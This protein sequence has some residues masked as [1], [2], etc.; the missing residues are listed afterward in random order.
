MR[1]DP[2]IQACADLVARGDPDR[3][4]ATLAAAVPARASLL[5]LYAFNLE[6]ARAPWVT[7]EPMIAEMR[8]QFWHDVIAEAA[9]GG[10]AK[11]HEVAGPFS[12]L[13]RHKNLKTDPL[14]A[15]VEARRWDIYCDPFDDSDAFERYLDATG[16]GLMWLAAQLLGAPEAFQIVIRGFG[17]AAAI[18]RLFLA[19][20]ELTRRRRRPLLDDRPGAIRDLAVSG[21]AGVRA[22]QTARL[23]KSIKPALWAGW[24]AEA[25]LRRAS[26]NPDHVAQGT[27][28]ESGFAQDAALLKRIWLNRV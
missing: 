3:Y 28:T 2:A 25:L 21:L 1:T 12:D 19:V 6:V 16:G 26:R 15:L 8:L 13:I 18:A 5:P 9:A 24:R 20:P 10:C 11:A 22:A 23:P 27:L 17:R 4:R 14:F 7:S